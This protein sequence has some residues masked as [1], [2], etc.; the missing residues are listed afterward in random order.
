MVPE[1][2]PV[3]GEHPVTHDEFKR[4]AAESYSL[5]REGQK[6]PLRLRRLLF[7]RGRSAAREPSSKGVAKR[8]TGQSSGR[9]RYTL[10]FASIFGAT[11]KTILD[12]SGVATDHKQET[13][14]ALHEMLQFLEPVSETVGTVDPGDQRHLVNGLATHK[15]ALAQQKLMP[16]CNDPR[17]K[18]TWLHRSGLKHVTMGVTA[19]VLVAHYVMAAT[20][21]NA[22]AVTECLDACITNATTLLREWD[23]SRAS[24]MS[25]HRAALQAERRALARAS[26]A[27]KAAAVVASVTGLDRLS[28][29]H[30]Q[31]SYMRSAAWS[32]GSSDAPRDEYSVAM[33]APVLGLLRCAQ[34]N[35]DTLSHSSGS[36]RSS[37]ASSSAA[38]SVASE[39][40]VYMEAGIPDA[41]E[42]ELASA[43]E[44]MRSI[45]NVKSNSIG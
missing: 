22:K 43:V 6:G 38:S 41:V 5:T 31:L 10:C 16:E 39:D 9:S 19:A 42:R 8:R 32:P 34:P 45:A 12:F 21:C 11:L 23:L 3:I 2:E 15:V 36:E 27:A 24:S 30:L 18:N 40:D 33:G 14:A 26:A 25:M 37:L 29:L 17:D 28:S 13:V 4:V 7:S 1:D 20:G 35:G 44:R